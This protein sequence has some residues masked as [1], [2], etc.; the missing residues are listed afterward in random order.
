MLNEEL[1]L[2][3]AKLKEES[4]LREE[5]KKAKTNL[6]TELAALCE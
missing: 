4:R 6:T 2:I 3:I 5:A 1:T